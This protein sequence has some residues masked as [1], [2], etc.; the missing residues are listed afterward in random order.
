MKELVFIHGRSQQGYDSIKLKKK[1]ID[2]LKDGMAKN[3]DTLPIAEDKIHFPYYGDTLAG[4]LNDVPEDEVAEIIVRGDDAS[5][6]ESEFVRSTILAILEK[7]GITDEQIQGESNEHIAERGILNWKWVQTG[8]SALDKYVPG[9]SGAAVAIATRDVYLY[10]KNPA[11]RK[12]ID[13]GVMRAMN[14]DAETVVV[15]HSLGAVVSYCVLHQYGESEG[16][17]VPLYVTVGAPLAVNAIKKVLRPIGHPAC[18]KKWF[19]AMDD[20]DVVA[21]YP[22]DSSHFDVDPAIENKTDVDNFTENR[23]SIDGYLSDP[24]VA[25]RIYEALV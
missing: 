24:V 17:K 8:L 15:G 22:L 23:H 16:W 2:C 4:L 6:A 3:G 10:F 1:W 14:R 12:I 11:V 13:S 7:Q 9:A 21:L 25:K 18:A 19:N 5:E 20:R